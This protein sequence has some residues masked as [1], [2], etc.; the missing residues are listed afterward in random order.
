MDS[1]MHEQAARLSQVH[2]DVS[3][4]LQDHVTRMDG[5]TTMIN[6]STQQQRQEV[7]HIDLAGLQKWG[8]EL[9]TLRTKGWKPGRQDV[10]GGTQM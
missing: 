5:M 9:M 8:E 10:H 7:P 4:R 2:E 3:R 6:T 1:K